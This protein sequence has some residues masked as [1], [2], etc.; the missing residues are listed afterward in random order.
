MG[1]STTTRRALWLTVIVGPIASAF[2][3][4][5]FGPGVARCANELSQQRVLDA[6]RL[7]AQGV[8]V[9]HVAGWHKEPPQAIV[10]YQV[11]GRHYEARLHGM[12]ATPQN[13]PLGRHITVE[14]SPTDPSVSRAAAL[15]ATTP[16]CS[17]PE[18]L[19]KSAL[20]GALLLLLVIEIVQ[21]FRGLRKTPTA[22]ESPPA[23]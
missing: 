4:A 16:S 3:L 18:L 13:L 12:G 1:R 17:E 20:I 23:P 19:F 7:T 8:I 14:Y 11:A 10:E 15:A 21:A 2:L 6:G 9:G 5:I 22:V